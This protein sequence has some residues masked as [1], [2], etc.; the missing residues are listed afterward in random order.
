MPL[1]GVVLSTIAI[2]GIAWAMRLA[3]FGASAFRPATR[4]FVFF[5]VFLI[6]PDFVFCRHSRMKSGEY[7]LTTR[8]NGRLEGKRVERVVFTV[9][10]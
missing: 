10:C 2:D 9:V 5:S 7:S 4:F 1:A 8:V 3:A 6:F